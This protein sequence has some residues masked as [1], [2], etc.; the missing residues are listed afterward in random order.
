LKLKGYLIGYFP[1]F[2]MPTRK[3]NFL[4]KLPFENKLL[5]WKGEVELS[6]ELI[7]ILDNHELVKE[8][9]NDLYIK[10]LLY[11]VVNFL[12]K[13]HQS[14]AASKKR[15]CFNFTGISA[16]KAFKTLNLFET[17]RIINRT[18]IGSKAR[19]ECSIFEIIDKELI[20]LAKTTPNKNHSS[21]VPLQPALRKIKRPTKPQILIKTAKSHKKK[22]EDL[23]KQKKL[24]P[25]NK[26]LSKNSI[27][28]NPS[29]KKIQ[30]D[31][32]VLNE[33]WKRTQKDMISWAGPQEGMLGADVKDL[34]DNQKGYENTPSDS[35]VSSVSSKPSILRVDAFCPRMIYSAYVDS[36]N[37]VHRYSAGGRVYADWQRLSSKQRL[38]L[39]INGQG[40]VEIDKVSS[41]PSILFAKRGKSLPRRFYEKLGLGDRAFGKALMMVMIG[42]SWKS[43]S[44]LL[45]CW[46][47]S[48][49]RSSGGFPEITSSHLRKMKELLGVVYNDLGDGAWK[50]VQLLESRWLIRVKE[51]FFKQVKSHNLYSVHDSI[52][53]VSSCRRILLKI[54]KRVWKEQFGVEGTFRVKSV[55]SSCSSS[56]NIIK[57]ARKTSSSLQT[58]YKAPQRRSLL[59]S[60]LGAGNKFKRLVGHHS[61][62]QRV[63]CVDD[64]VGLNKNKRNLNMAIHTIGQSNGEEHEK[65][66]QA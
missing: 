7:K 5:N 29:S 37:N 35:V 3:T 17:Q 36:G 12:N 56:V 10:T 57:K 45:R 33:S 21:F 27:K 6:Q 34:F 30:H 48:E 15:A 43:E 54:M 24:S 61:A 63:F 4:T 18:S 19:G 50:E 66:I 65:Q 46:K 39:L 2:V 26:N 64:E 8:N 55:V 51:L 23:K 49:A 28:A 62:F 53:V 20:Q 31:Q 60:Q 42:G 59:R 40:V 47:F 52:V 41:Q 11:H 22:L 44:S 38:N 58:A 16:D 13:G 9:P 25:S 32:K 14:F 1:G